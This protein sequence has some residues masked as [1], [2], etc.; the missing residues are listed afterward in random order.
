[1]N[2]HVNPAAVSGDVDRG[3]VAYLERLE[4]IRQLDRWAMLWE[5]NK[6]HKEINEGR[7]DDAGCVP[8]CPPR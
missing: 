2:D 1:M 8:D 6:L 4:A 5:S 7:F 3:R